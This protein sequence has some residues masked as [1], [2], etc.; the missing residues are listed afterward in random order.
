MEIETAVYDIPQGCVTSI[1]DG[2]NEAMFDYNAIQLPLI[3]R[4][5]I[6]GDRIQPYG[7]QGTKK[8]KDYLMDAKV[9]LW[10]RDQIPIVISDNDIIWIIGFT[11][12]E[13]YKIHRHTQRVLHL[14][15][16]KR[17]INS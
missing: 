17:E 6:A 7:M 10:E 13:R 4:N 8:L 3:V 9:P 2:I 12:C 16:G 11:T 1:P 15:Y 5:R 14:Y